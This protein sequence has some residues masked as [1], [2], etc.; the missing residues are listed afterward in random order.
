[1]IVVNGF[2]CEELKQHLMA[3]GTHPVARRHG[4]MIV[5]GGIFPSCKTIEITIT[6]NESFTIQAANN[7]VYYKNSDF[8]NV[9]HDK[10]VCA[11]CT[12]FNWG[13][14]A[15]IGDMKDGEF[16][17]NY[18][19]ATGIGTGNVSFK[20]NALFDSTSNAK[21]WFKEQVEK[22]TPVTIVAYIKE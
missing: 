18:T 5:A 14:G 2:V 1:M 8:V 13:E 4:N 9:P 19:K 22:G 21:A 17:F 20:I 11:H 16:I 7:T 3:G 15:V 6:G 12:H 10:I